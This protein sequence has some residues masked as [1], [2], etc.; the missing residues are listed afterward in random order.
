MKSLVLTLT[1]LFSCISAAGQVKEPDIRVLA[2]ET[3]VKTRESTGKV[4]AASNILPGNDVLAAEIERGPVLTGLTKDLPKISTATEHPPETTEKE[5]YQPH[6]NR[7]DDHDDTGPLQI[8]NSFHWK[9]AL[10][11][12]GL[13]LL[14]QHSFR[15]T[16]PK[17]TRELGGKFFADWGASVMNL[18]GWADGNKGFTNYFAHPMQGSLTGRIF[19]NNSGRAKRQEFGPSKEYWTSRLKAMAWTAVWSTQFEIGPVSE[20]T[21]GN[22]GQRL[23]PNGKSKMSYVDF[24]ITPTMG[25][26]FAIVEDAIDKYVLKNWIERRTSSKLKIK[27][28]RSILTPNMSFA[29]LLR[30]KM[31][32]YRDFRL[33]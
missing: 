15:M 29:N 6:G 4:E 18:K 14:I 13:F 19:I 17:T 31:P 32:W 2:A 23:Y 8:D 30:G 28:L 5:S 11:Q 9:P 25:T 3:A 20:A 27:F 12:S 1:V 21:L 22:V 33:D 7:S 16:Q 26:G 10:V 24:V